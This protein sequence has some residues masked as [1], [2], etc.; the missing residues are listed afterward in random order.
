MKE[1]DKSEIIMFL[2]NNFHCEENLIFEKLDYLKSKFKE[3]QV[4]Y[5]EKYKDHNENLF[6]IFLFLTGALAEIVNITQDEELHDKMNQFVKMQL[7]GE[8]EDIVKNLIE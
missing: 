1:K 4:E 3:T 6:G 5:F 2:F 8:I 7:E